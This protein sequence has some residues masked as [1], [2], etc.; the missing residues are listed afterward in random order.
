MLGVTSSINPS[1]VALF[2]KHAGARAL[3][4]SIQMSLGWGCTVLAELDVVASTF[5]LQWYSRRPHDHIEKSAKLARSVKYTVANP[6]P[7]AR[8]VSEPATSQST[9]RCSDVP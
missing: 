6:I 8:G 1:K 3:N 4:T 7:S 9:W 5:L 2:L